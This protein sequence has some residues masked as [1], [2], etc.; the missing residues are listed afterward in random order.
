MQRLDLLIDLALSSV[1]RR[2]ASITS[3]TGGFLNILEWSGS[4]TWFLPGVL[5][6]AIVAWFASSSIG[7]YL[8]TSR[9]GA[10]LLVLSLGAVLSATV[11]PIQPLITDGVHAQTCDLSRIGLAPLGYFRSINDTSLNVLLFIPLGLTAGLVPGSRRKVALVA[12]LVALPFAIEALQLAAPVLA[13]GCQ[14]ADVVDNLTGLV[15]GLTV[16]GLVRLA[17]RIATGPGSR[18]GARRASLTR[19]PDL[20]DRALVR[21]GDLWHG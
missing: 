8:R 4:I 15:A 10:F 7:G 20:S 21:S 11:T 1:K 9:V 14:S 16:A 6:S 5:V 19:R 3:T 2:P 18:T 12:G 17:T 13:R